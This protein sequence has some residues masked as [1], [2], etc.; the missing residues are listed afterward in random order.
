VPPLG[1]VV[2]VVG[3]TVVDVLDETVVVLEGTVVEVLDGTEVDVGTVVVVAP[4]TSKVNRT[5]T[6]KW[7]ERS[8][9][10]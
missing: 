6:G 10:V 9:C 7:S 8:P 5:V 2:D 1:T 3:V 4:M